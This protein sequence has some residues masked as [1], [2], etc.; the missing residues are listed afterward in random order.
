MRALPCAA[1]HLILVWA[2]LFPRRIVQQL[3][4]TVLVALGG[5]LAVLGGY[6]SLVV[7]PQ[8][9]R[10]RGV[11]DT[12]DTLLGGGNAKATDRIMTLEAASAA[13]ATAHSL[14]ETRLVALELVANDHVPR[15]G[16]IRYNAFEDTG[17]DL[18]Y[19]LALLNKSGD[20]VVISSV[21]SREET[22]TYGKAIT[23]FGS[24][25]EVSAEER[26]A[27]A[28]ARAVSA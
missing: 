1:N 25:V 16:F 13:R 19:A 6:H 27:I 17:S 23:N 18:S 8:M 21:W 24:A 4:S 10:L 2:S 15:V 9:R 7:A 3:T 5:A 14:I 28:K 12:H 20:G 11:S 26:A 22:R